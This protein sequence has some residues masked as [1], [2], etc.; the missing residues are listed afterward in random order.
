MICM[1]GTDTLCFFCRWTEGGGRVR[2]GVCPRCEGDGHALIYVVV[3][4]LL[5]SLLYSVSF[6]LF[7]SCVF[8]L[9]YINHPFFHLNY[10]AFT[11]PFGLSVSIHSY[12]LLLVSWSQSI[13]FS[14]RTP[15]PHK[16]IQKKR[17]RR[18]GGGEEGRRGGKETYLIQ[19]KT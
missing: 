4:F 8:D 14:S 6:R 5:Y 18:R 13:C 9:P 11:R 2:T 17:E 7:F 12:Y 10:T 3:I 19:K 15:P 1:W 16:S